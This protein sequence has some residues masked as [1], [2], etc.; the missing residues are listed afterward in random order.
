MVIVPEYKKPLG[1]NKIKNKYPKILNKKITN[2]KSKRLKK[3]SK[4][5]VG[6]L[7]IMMKK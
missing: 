6:R 7:P 5:T 4:M 3:L 1:F 2:L